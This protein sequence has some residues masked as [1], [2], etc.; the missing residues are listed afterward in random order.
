MKHVTFGDGAVLMGDEAADTLLE[1]AR[2]TADA[3]RA[4]SVTLRAISPDGNTVARSC[5]VAG[6]G[7]ASPPDE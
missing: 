5:A 2:V 6:V 1:Y 3:S 4:D 7:R